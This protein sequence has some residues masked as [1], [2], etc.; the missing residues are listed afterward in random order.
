[1]RLE[2]CPSRY[3]ISWASPAARS[4]SLIPLWRR[5]RHPRL[6][7][8]KAY[9]SGMQTVRTKGPD[10][11]TP[12]FKRAVELDPNFA[13]AYAYLGVHGKHDS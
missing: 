12:F 10:A 9:S 1:M 6:R 4:R 3:G 2:K 11:A 8:L 7:P 5:R 13:V